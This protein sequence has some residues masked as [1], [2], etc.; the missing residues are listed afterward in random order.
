M[1]CTVSKTS[2]LVIKFKFRIIQN[3][4]QQSNINLIFILQHISFHQVVA[5]DVFQEQPPPPLYQQNSIEI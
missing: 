4:V 3:L 5:Q 2:K 1:R